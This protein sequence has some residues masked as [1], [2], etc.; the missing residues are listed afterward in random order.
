MPAPSPKA[1]ETGCGATAVN[2]AVAVCPWYGRR[3]RDGTDQ[4]RLE[5]PFDGSTLAIVESLQL[6]AALDVTM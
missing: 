6:Q 4:P 3:Y 2:V 5:E 1:S